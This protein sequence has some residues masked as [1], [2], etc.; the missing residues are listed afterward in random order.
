MRNISGQ[1]YTYLQSVQGYIAP[2]IAAVFLVGIFWRRVNAAGALASLGTGFVLGAA[3]LVLELTHGAD[4]HGLPAGSVW[5]ALAEIN[6]LHLAFGLFVI[7]C[8]VLVGVSLATP[9]PPA[10]RTEGITFVPYRSRSP[11]PPRPDSP[12]RIRDRLLSAC[13][14]VG[15]GGLWLWFS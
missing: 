3:R 10:E 11:E 7:C 1:L 15:V 4:R 2:P 6:F 12:W 8:L 13:L 9:P 14:L 5:A